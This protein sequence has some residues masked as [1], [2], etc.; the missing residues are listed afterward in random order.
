MVQRSAFTP[1]EIAE[2]INSDDKEDQG[3]AARNLWS[4]WK[5]W[6]EDINIEEGED[7]EEKVR[8]LFGP[9]AP[10]I[11]EL[12][13]RDIE[14]LKSES[15]YTMPRHIWHFLISLGCLQYEEAL[16]D[17]RDILMDTSIVENVRGFAAE[18]LTR[19]D[20]SQIPED[21]IEDLWKLAL[22]DN[23]LPVRVNSIRAISRKYANT[24][25]EEVSKRLW[26]EIVTDENINHAII[27]TAMMTIGEI[28]SKVLVPDLIH[29]MI[30]RRTGALKK[31][32][33]LTLDRIAELN[34]MR[35]RDDLIKSLDSIE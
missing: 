2:M 33:A 6:Q 31:D 24:K 20:A 16:P 35:N 25:N 15:S 17:I 7:P 3:V 21:F 26:D 10:K 27:S 4:F 18:A 30:T 22:T 23:S 8:D 19:Y 14:L 11:Y 29:M 32:A 1:D 28:G 34:G 13:Q 12:L 5:G 9:L